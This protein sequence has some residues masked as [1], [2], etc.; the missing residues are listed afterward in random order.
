MKRSTVWLCFVYNNFSDV[1]VQWDCFLQAL[2]GF[3]LDDQVM[4]NSVI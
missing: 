3:S 4:P 1:K 2:I